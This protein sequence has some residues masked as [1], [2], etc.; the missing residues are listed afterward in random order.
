MR[1]EIAVAVPAISLNMVGSVPDAVDLVVTDPV[2]T[3]A[4]ADADAAKFDLAGAGN[5]VLG[6]VRRTRSDNASPYTA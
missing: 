3:D 6:R 4:M 2:Q 5:A 1:G